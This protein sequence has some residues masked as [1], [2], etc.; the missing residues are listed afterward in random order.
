MQKKILIVTSKS[1]GGSGKHI[2]T[3]AKGMKSKGVEVSLLYYAH[4]F[5]Q[6]REIEKYFDVTYLF[7]K[8]I[9]FNFG[10]L[11][12]LWYLRSVIKRG[13]YE[14]VHSHTS[15]GGLICR[16]HAILCRF[17]KIRYIHTLHAYAAD[18][19]TPQPQ[20]TIY[21]FIEKALDFVTDYYVA[22]SQFTA[23]Y[24][25]RMNLFRES[26]VKTIHNALDLQSPKVT[27]VQRGDLIRSSLG[28]KKSDCMFLFCGRLEK[29]KGLYTLLDSLNLTLVK[30]PNAKLVIVGDGTLEN[31]LKKYVVDKKLSENVIFAGW[32]SEVSDYYAASDAFVM[33]SIWESFGLVFLEAMNY[34]KPVIASRTQGIPEVVTEGET[35]Y[36]C[37]VNNAKEFSQK[38]ILLAED[39]NKRIQ[40]GLA[41]KAKL[42][43]KF[44][45]SK[46]IDSH[47]DL[48]T[49]VAE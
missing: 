4:G 39:E 9:G 40:L 20:K 8:K 22:P 47:L 37:A 43:N 41:G 42:Q 23:N 14:I 38:M 46:F 6:D 35:G 28:I 3:L 33:S 12:N 18:Q 24:G 1:A 30:C 16:L 45:F 2:E 19:F 44:A 15:L 32:Q 27:E 34:S 11:V 21:Y 25:V 17:R 48:Y 10:F 49:E 5:A 13:N 31:D 26:K 29:Q 7:P 36:L